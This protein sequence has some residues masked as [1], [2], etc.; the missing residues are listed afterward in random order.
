[1]TSSRIRRIVLALAILTIAAAVALLL[2]RGDADRND[3]APAA[4]YSPAATPGPADPQPQPQAA[5]ASVPESR[6][7]GSQASRPIAAIVQAAQGLFGDLPPLAQ[8]ID[9]LTRRADA[10]DAVASCQLGAELMR[11]GERKE[12]GFFVAGT[13]Q[14]LAEGDPW[15]RRIARERATLAE[16]E[17]H[18]AGI[19]DA[20]IDETPRRI[21]AAADAGN[22]AAAGV[23]ITAGGMWVR[24]RLMS[25]PDLVAR[26]RDGYPRWVDRAFLGGQRRSI[27]SL[28]ESSVSGSPTNLGLQALAR[29]S[30]AMRAFDL[31][32]THAVSEAGSAIGDLPALRLSQSDAV[33]D[34]PARARAEALAMHWLAAWKNMPRTDDPDAV[35]PGDISMSRLAEKRARTLQVVCERG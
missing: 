10:G 7:P 13:P 23:A 22:A 17:R 29:D 24:A 33:L 32:L 18:C 14:Q 26:L 27:Q 8:R 19:A 35:D 15:A 9:D 16:L 30:V 34:A 31:F 20:R 12:L 4:P 5:A 1:M 2:I 6:A 21:F 25:E 28:I 11:C 3:T